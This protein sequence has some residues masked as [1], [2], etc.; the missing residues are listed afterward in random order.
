MTELEAKIWL[1][2]VLL[3]NWGQLVNSGPANG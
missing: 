2:R 3:A 1:L